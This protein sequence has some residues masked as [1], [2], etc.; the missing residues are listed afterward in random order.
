MRP[1]DLISIDR[2]SLDLEAEC[3]ERAMVLSQQF[4]EKVRDTEDHMW[5]L[6]TCDAAP[7]QSDR[8]VCV[9][10]CF[11]LSVASFLFIC[12]QGRIYGHWTLTGGPSI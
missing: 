7:A 1:V 11:S 5:K 12:M 10:V 8:C 4:Q 6:A 9:C 3:L 2:R